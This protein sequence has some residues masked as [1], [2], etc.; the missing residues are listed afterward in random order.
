MTN[1]TDTMYDLVQP[2]WDELLFNLYRMKVFRNWLIAKGLHELWFHQLF[3]KLPSI[4]ARAKSLRSLE[5]SHKIA[6]SV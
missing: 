4:W 1:R 2:E 6:C 5:G 3:M